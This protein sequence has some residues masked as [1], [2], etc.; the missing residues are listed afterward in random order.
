MGWDI[1]I[2]S[3]IAFTQ[4][5]ITW[6]GVHVSV[7]EHRIRNA[8]IIGLLG[9]AGIGLTIFGAIRSGTAQQALQNQLDSIQRN[10]EKTPTVNV[11]PQINLPSPPPKHA[12]VDY[13]VK[14]VRESPLLPFHEGQKPALNIG[15]SNGSSDV[16]ISSSSLR[17]VVVVVPTTYLDGSFQKHISEIKKQP[18]AISQ[19]INPL[20]DGGYATY[21]APPITAEDVLQLNAGKEA[22]CGLALT[23]WKDES[24]TYETDFGVCHIRETNTPGS[25]NMHKL[26]IHQRERTI[27]KAH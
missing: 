23:I 20:G 10:T 2:A 13:N 7:S 19:T 12:H 22:V 24:G 5:V 14:T 16:A 8:V 26:S 9:A 1:L 6:Y 25:F 27:N 17:A 21:T 3:G 4:L 11:N 18:P 15:F